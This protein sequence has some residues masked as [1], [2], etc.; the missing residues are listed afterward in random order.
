MNPT[1]T[2]VVLSLDAPLVLRPSILCT[3]SCSR[4]SLIRLIGGTQF[5]PWSLACQLLPNRLSGLS[6]VASASVYGSFGMSEAS[7]I[8]LPNLKCARH[9]HNG[10]RGSIS[11]LIILHAFSPF[12]CFSSWCVHRVL[13]CRTNTILRRPQGRSVRSRRLRRSSRRGGRGAYPGLDWFPSHFCP[14]HGFLWSLLRR[15]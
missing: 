3:I 11:P 1:R 12:S 2:S 6:Y 10:V 5:L 7:R 14:L 13:S 4:R 9:A 8:L 15:R